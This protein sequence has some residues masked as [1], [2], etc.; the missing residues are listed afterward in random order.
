MIFFTTLICHQTAVT[1][2][3]TQV[4]VV[5][6]RGTT[7]EKNVAVLAQQPVEGVLSA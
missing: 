7:V 4:G 2:F 3:T 1:V 6:Y 5:I